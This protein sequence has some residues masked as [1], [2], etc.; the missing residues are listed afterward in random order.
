MLWKAYF[1]V[2][3]LPAVL[4]SQE[5]STSQKDMVLATVDHKLSRS[6]ANRHTTK[7]LGSITDIEGNQYRTIKINNQEWMI[8]NLKAS[9]YQTG[10][11]IQLINDHKYWAEADLGAYCWYNNDQQ[12]ESVHGKLYNWKAVN[13]RRGI[14]PIGWR[15]P[16][17]EDWKE[18]ITNLGGEQHGGG[19]MK[20]SLHWHSPNHEASNESGF[21]GLPSGYRSRTGHFSLTGEAG[22]WWSNTME[23]NGFQAAYIA[24]H[25][26]NGTAYTYANDLETG[27]AVRCIKAL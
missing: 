12:V 14:C 25:H 18:L 8:D 1:L 26:A 27:F 6:I 2:I 10:D 24:L 9:R 4:H 19:K 5:E 16:S 3:I 7:K 17:D 22:F 13:D 21:S 15:I 23:I 11:S 20:D